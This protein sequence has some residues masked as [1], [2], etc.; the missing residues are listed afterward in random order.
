MLSFIT[1]FG[2]S[3]V[4][5]TLAALLAVWLAHI[6]GRRAMLAWLA[7]LLLCTA[8]IALLKIYFMA[9]PLREL[10]LRSPSGHSGFSLYVYGGICLC[11]MR[12][13][14]LWRRITL[15]LLGLAWIAAIAFSRV[16]LRAH[17]AGETWLGL[18][19][20]AVA[21][22]AFA[23]GS[24]PLP[25][26]RFPFFISAAFAAAIAAPL[27]LLPLGFTFEPWLRHLART[28]HA[29]VPLCARA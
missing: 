24:G 7:G 29:I 26:Q 6:S 20:G 28:V 14:L 27:L 19:L 22:T 21:L 17:S 5:I 4:L 16:A 11:L 15:P 1:Q 18:A 3:F 10:G 12:D 25:Q 13:P 23:I 2:H 8:S 9:C